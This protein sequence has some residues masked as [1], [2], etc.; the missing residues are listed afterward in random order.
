MRVGE[1]IS[2]R[3]A[4]MS[5]YRRG[6]VEINNAKFRKH[7]H[8]SRCIT[9]PPWAL[10]HYAE[11]RD[12]QLCPETQRGRAFSSPHA[13]PGCSTSTSTRCSESSWRSGSQHRPGLA[14]LDPRAAPQLRHGKFGGFP[15]WEPTQRGCSPLL[16]AYLGH[17][18]PAWTYVYLQ[19]SSGAASTWRR[20]SGR[21]EGRPAM[22]ALA[23]DVE[24]FFTERLHH[25]APGEPK[26][27][28]HLP[29]QAGGC[30]S[31]SPGPNRKS[32][33]TARCA[34]LDAKL[35]G[36][37]L[38]HL[39]AGPAQQRPHAQHPLGGDPLTVSL[40]G[41]S[42][43]G[44]RG[45]DPAGAR[46]PQQAPRPQRGELSLLPRRSTLFLAAPDRRH[47]GPEDT[48][49]P[50]WVLTVQTGPAGERADPSHLW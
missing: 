29:R 16:S 48:T 22:R 34:D 15:P 41:S 27:C 36:T 43:S 10:R 23:P 25:P 21:F 40:C 2:P 8:S 24:A 12:D 9:R 39:E 19:G 7:R 13:A 28:H 46:H 38:A 49:T 6:V 26:D 1:A 14:L 44:A 37:F 20:T 45:A 11:V 30:C 42:P 18:D 4:A 17:G 5:T 35:I 3:P 47:L 50:C 33:F 31:A 32:S